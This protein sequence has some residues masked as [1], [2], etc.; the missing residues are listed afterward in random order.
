MKD[1][2]LIILAFA[3]LNAGICQTGNGKVVRFDE[4][5]YKSYFEQ[6]AF[7]GY[8]QGEKDF[9]KLFMAVDPSVNTT[10]YDITR[11]EIE[12]ELQRLNNRKFIKAK[13]EKKILCCLKMLTGI[14]LR[15]MKRMFS[16]PGYSTMVSSIA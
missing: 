1:I 14:Y 10:K 13:P 6:L 4:L 12:F 8:H 16:F 11:R 15:G 7:I 5:S 9:L 2:S 3:F